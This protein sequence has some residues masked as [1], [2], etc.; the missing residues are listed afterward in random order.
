MKYKIL[1]IFCVICA[2][3]F[4][5]FSVLSNTGSKKNADEIYKEMSAKAQLTEGLVLRD[6]SFFKKTFGVSA[7][8]FESVV[9]YSSDD[10]MNVNELLIIK[11]DNKESAENLEENIKKYVADNYEIFNGYAPEQSERLQNYVLEANTNTLFFFVGGNS[12]AAQDAFNNA[13]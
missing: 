11:F 5:A 6:N 2:A 4:I 7:D 8:E 12:E 9:Y 1:E 3:V 13:L 10:V